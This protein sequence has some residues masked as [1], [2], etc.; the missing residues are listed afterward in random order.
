MGTT[1]VA[2]D[3]GGF[4]LIEMV[5]ALAIIAILMAV[6][7][8]SY[9]EQMVQG[10]RSDGTTALTIFSQRMERY[11]LEN[12]SYS[13]ATT[14]IYKSTSDNEYYLLS[15]TTTGESYQLLA[16]AT[17]IQAGDAVC[18]NLTLNEKGERGITGSGSAI[19]CWH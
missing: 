3:R 8:P 5:I 9:E 17:G 6:S 13:G 11:F 2:A 14:S 1:S 4:T 12:G 15:V 18:G 16:T 7:L 10:R 19:D